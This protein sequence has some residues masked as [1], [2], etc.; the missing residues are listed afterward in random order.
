MRVTVRIDRD[1]AGPI[2]VIEELPAVAIDESSGSDVVA[3]I[4]HEADR[5][6]RLLSWAA[7]TARIRLSAAAD[8]GE[9]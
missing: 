2:E 5:A 1:L 4:R 9:C 8:G 6:E 7:V 3:A